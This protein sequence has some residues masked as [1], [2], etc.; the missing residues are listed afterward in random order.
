M[1]SQNNLNEGSQ[2]EVWLRSQMVDQAAPHLGTENTLRCRATCPRKQSRSSDH[3][4]SRY[5]GQTVIYPIGPHRDDPAS[6]NEQ[7]PAS[8]HNGTGIIWQLRASRVCGGHVESL[9]GEG[10]KGLW[11]DASSISLPGG[12]EGWSILHRLVHAYSAL[13]VSLCHSGFQRMEVLLG[14]A[15]SGFSKQNGFVLGPVLMWITTWISKWRN[16]QQR[17]WVNAPQPPNL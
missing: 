8:K 16:V 2:A 11:E 6:G 14:L 4:H 5:W 10:R 7:Y 17:G 13:W 9:A 15:S 1:A 3:H 12:P